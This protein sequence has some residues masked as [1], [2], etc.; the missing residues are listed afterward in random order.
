[1]ESAGVFANGK[2][3]VPVKVKN[4]TRQQYALS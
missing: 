1:M 2:Q 4:I 3:S